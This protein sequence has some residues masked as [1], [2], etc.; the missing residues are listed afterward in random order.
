MQGLDFIGYGFKFLFGGMEYKVGIILA[1]HRPVSWNA[2]H[3]QIVNLLEFHRFGI[4]RAGHAG[5]F[6]I[7][8]EIVLEG[9]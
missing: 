2:D 1:D 8:A 9:D 7:H 6:F 3:V 4:R 5:Q